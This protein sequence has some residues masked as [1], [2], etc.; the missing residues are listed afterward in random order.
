M[1]GG[2][3]QR[4]YVPQVIGQVTA[5]LPC[6][7]MLEAH[8]RSAIQLGA[9][10]AGY[11]SARTIGADVVQNGLNTISAERAFV[12]ADTRLLS[13][14]RQ[15]LV[16]HFAIWSQFQHGLSRVDGDVRQTYRKICFAGS[17]RQWP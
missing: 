5:L 9:D 14:R 17:P 2:T 3:Y 12:G 15:I 13:I 8:A 16:A 6:G 10:R 4:P 7:L 11:K 1:L